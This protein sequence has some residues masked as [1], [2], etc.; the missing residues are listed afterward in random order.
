M[1]GFSLLVVGCRAT[2]LQTTPTPTVSQLNLLTTSTTTPLA[3]SLSQAYIR[4]DTLFLIS[5]HETNWRGVENQIAA[6][7][8]L[9]GMTTFLPEGSNLWAAPLGEDG[10]AIIT[11]PGTKVPVLI[12][13]QLR[14]IFS[15][16]I[17]SWSKV[18]GADMPITVV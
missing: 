7:P 8:S 10:I 18:G 6:D 14:G 11:H 9:Y 2:R 1:V 15:G 13:S 12:A 4:Q 17:G 3:Q 16:G 5:L